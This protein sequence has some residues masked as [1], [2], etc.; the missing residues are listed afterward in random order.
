MYEYPF[1]QVVVRL[2]LFLFLML[3]AVGVGVL[4]EPVDV[5]LDPDSKSCS[6][7]G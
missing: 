3:L 6:P 7:R 4:F 5:Q 1:A 2:S